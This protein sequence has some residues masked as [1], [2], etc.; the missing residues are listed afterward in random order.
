LSIAAPILPDTESLPPSQVKQ[1]DA[2]IAAA[3]RLRS[4]NG[5][6]IVSSSTLI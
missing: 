3:R 4:P 1:I 6:P 2:T 5:F